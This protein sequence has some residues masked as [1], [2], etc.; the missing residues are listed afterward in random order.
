M[1]L[2]LGLRLWLAPHRGHVH[3]ITQFKEWTR[4]LVMQNPLAIYSSSTANYPPLALLPLDAMGQ[5]YRRLVSP[6]MVDSAM[7]TALLK[8]PAIL[9][10]LVTTTLIWCLVKRDFRPPVALACAAA[11]AFNPAV[12]YTSAWWGQ[13][14]ALY[15]LP[16]L[17][18]VVAVNRRRVAW[19]WVWLAVGI[20]VKPQAA[21]VAPVILVASWQQERWRAWLKGGLAGGLTLAAVLT[22]LA[23][24]GQ[25]RPLLA[26]LQA[27]AGKQRFLTMNAHNLWYL[28]TAGRGSF[29]AR[30]GTPL[31]DDIPLLGPF[32]GWQIGLALLAFWTLACC[33]LLTR[34]AG[35]RPASRLLLASRAGA[36]LLFATGRGPRAVP[37]SGAG[38]VD[39]PLAPAAHLPC[40]VRLSE[41]WV[42]S[43]SL[44]GGPGASVAGL[45]RAV[46]LGDAY[47]LLNVASAVLL[48]TAAAGRERATAAPSG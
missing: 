27:S 46:E 38:P 31:T 26:Q 36:G 20:L 34:P 39:A 42:V 22:P 33:W 4:L 14:E 37:L 45:C 41:P 43:Q 47:R 8:L 23:A 1:L 32:T 25:L 10:D 48:V 35:R 13:L 12:W 11:Y 29:A 17:V 40:S 5:L 15:A 44:V 9:A 7:L 24:A 3:D 6:E 21:V 28:V 16:M 2:A 30:A 19:A 18:S